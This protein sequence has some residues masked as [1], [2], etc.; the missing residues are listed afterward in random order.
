MKELIIPQINQKESVFA[1]LKNRISF[2]KERVEALEA[3]RIQRAV[4][5]NSAGFQ[6]VLSLL[7]ALLHYNEPSLIGYVEQAPAGFYQFQINNAQQDFLTSLAIEQTNASNFP[8]FDGLY[9]MGSFGSVTQTALS[10]LDLWLCHT[11]SF[12]TEQQQAL[13]EKLSLIQCWAK[14][15]GVELQ[16]Y[17]MNPIHFRAQQYSSDVTTEHSGSAQHFFLLD[18]FYR[19]AIRLAGK[20][21]LWLH[22]NEQDYRYV[23]QQGV[24]DLG[25]W[26]DFGDLSSLSISEYFGASLWQLYKGIKNPYKSAIKILLLE[27]YAQTYP[28]THLISLKFKQKLFS[29]N[30]VQYH[31]D[32]YLAM[33]EQ[34]TE[35]L[36]QRKE[37]VRLDRLR[38]CFYLKAIEGQQTTWRINYLQELAK[39]WGWSEKELHHLAS[40]ENWKIKQAMADQQMLVEQLLQSYRNLIHFAR[41]F[42]IDPSIMPQDTDILMRKLYSVFEVLPGKVTLINE[43]IA[44]QLEEAEVTFI[45]VTESSS[46]RAGWYLVNH[47]P[48]SPYDSAKRYVQ[49]Q[50]SL[51]KLVAWAYFNGVVTVNTQ[52][53]I[54]SQRVSLARLRKFI[55]DLRLTFPVKPPPVQD[56]DLYHPNEIRNLIVA[57]NLTNDPTQKIEAQTALSQLD[58][59][60]LSSSEQGI[61]GSISLIYR[62]MWNE[63]IAQHFEGTD[64]ILK[65]LKLISNKIYRSSAPPES[66]NVFCYSTQLRNELQKFVVSLVNRCISVQTGV[67][68]QKQ[69]SHPFNLA[70]KRWQFIFGK[71]VE[72]KE[73]L[74]EKNVPENNT[75]TVP[76]EIYNFASEGFLQ[77]F[78]EDNA[79]QSFNVYVLD[80]RNHI[81]SYRQC[82]GSKT[83]KIKQINRLYAEG[84]NEHDCCSLESFNF[85]QFYQLILQSEGM[86]IVPF[87]SKQ[88]RE[89]LAHKSQTKT[90]LDQILM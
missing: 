20:R 89:Y 73:V 7:P 54:V 11:K 23:T 38:Y 46:Q 16:F 79:D 48:L 4:A 2:A 75:L 21:I 1:T 74:N 33:L 14:D 72:L 63:V 60:N 30:R 65:A 53:H 56:Q 10:D 83:E 85:P 61:V 82:V 69:H 88:H 43:K 66:V 8:A 62:N 27:S 90:C 6:T 18:E 42:H 71:Q 55:S 49:Y 40:R 39:N 68:S 45:E 12:S 47:A 76:A 51:T 37:Y 77:F 15:F 24:A 57:V 59:F 78:F 84:E 36:E 22:L 29:T 31:F 86:V 50:K 87:Q 80:K 19:S 25:D 35:Y 17:L 81:E 41:K 58:L 13:A 44:T 9:V 67:I 28:T 70:G 3:L 26:I 5:E 64:A 34:V 52:L 32:P